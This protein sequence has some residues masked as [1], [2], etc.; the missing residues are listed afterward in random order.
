[1]SK[2]PQTKSSSFSRDLPLTLMQS[3]TQKAKLESEQ[4]TDRPAQSPICNILDLPT[5]LLLQITSLLPMGSIRNLMV[6]R[7]LRSVCEQGLY[8]SISL[9]RHPRRSIRL[10]ETFLLRPDLAL[11]VQHLEIDCNFNLKP[12]AIPS[13]PQLEGLGALSLAQNI[14]SLSVRAIGD[15]VRRL[16]QAQPLLEEFKLL[17]TEPNQKSLWRFFQ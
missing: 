1:M 5:E 7:W 15:A 11:L 16:L 14:R 8:Q 10:L 2:Y 9:P 6:N 17:D 12:G 13:A 3:P 4:A